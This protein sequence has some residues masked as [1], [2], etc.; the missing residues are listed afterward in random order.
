MNNS[1]STSNIG[2]VDSHND[3]VHKFTLGEHENLSVL[4]WNVNDISDQS[5]GNKAEIDEFC[6]IIEMAPI[7]CLQETKGEVNVPNYRC[8]NKNRES[9][10]SGGLCIGVQRSLLN[11][12]TP[13]KTESSDIQA[14]SI[15][16]A[17]TRGDKNIT[18]INIYDSQDYSSYKVRMKKLGSEENTLEALLHLIGEQIS[19]SDIMLVG[20]L[21]ARTGTINFTPSSRDWM[22]EKIM[23]APASCRASKDPVLNERG[24]KFIDLLSSCNLTLLNG[25]VVGDIFGEFTCFKYNGQSVADYM[26][27]TPNLKSLV[28]WFKVLS[29]TDL[30]DHKPLLCKF[31]VKVP[32]LPAELIE[33]LYQKAPTKPKWDG[34]ATT[35]EFI[36]NLNRD[37]Q[38]ARL[39]EL[40]ASP[41]ENTENIYS[42]NDKFINILENSLGTERNPNSSEHKVKLFS[43]KKRRS[44]FRPKQ[45]WF[46]AE[47]IT[48]KRELNKLTRR[49][50]KNP[51]DD[52]LRTRF[53]TAKKEYKKLIKKK[54]SLFFIELNQEILQDDQISWKNLKTVKK[55]S[56]KP[57]RLDIFDMSKFYQFFMDLYKKRDTKFPTNRTI[58]QVEEEVSNILNDKILENEIVHAVKSL[59]NGKAVGLDRV[60]NEQLKSAAQNSRALLV[61]AKLF[62][63]CLDLG[64]YPW[65]TTI[66]S[67]LHKKGCIY[68][69]DNYRAIAI[70]SN[71]GKLFATILLN[72]LLKFREAHCP[73]TTN[74]L[75]FCK[76]A[77]T[78]DHLFT[79]TTCVDKY[80]N[81]QKKRLYSCFVDFQKAFDSISR[82]ALLYKLSTLGIGGKFLKCLE[83]MYKNS[84]AKIKLI[85]KI[86]DSFDILAGT[87]QGH[88]MSPELF[89]TYIHEL[90]E[91]LNN[92]QG[93]ECPALNDI[94]LTHLLWADDLVLLALTKKSL[95]EMIRELESFCIEWGLTVNIKKTAIMIFNRSGRQLKEST[96]FQYEGREIPTA[97]TYC[98]LG[99]TFSL[100]GSFKVAQNLLRQKALRA[101]FGLK[102]EVDLYSISKVAVLKLLDS[103]ILP[104]VSYG[105][106]VW[107]T[108]T[109]GIK[110]FAN[111]T[112]IAKQS[113]LTSLAVDPI[114]RLHLSILKWTLGVGK[115]T[116]NAAVW[117]DCGRTPLVVR[118]VKQVTDFYNRLAKMDLDDSPALARHAFAEQKRLGLGW[119]NTLAKMLNTLDENKLEHQL[120]NSL[121]CQDRA[122]NR[123]IATWEAE[124]HNNSKLGFYNEVKD[125]FNMEPYLQIP[126]KKWE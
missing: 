57:S 59:K 114:E 103:L 93:L 7:F 111:T 77:R 80:V 71:L 78:V 121:L 89:K 48:T 10:R 31:S 28:K 52:H 100:S 70:G 106:E 76:N 63:G 107:I 46:D 49:Y 17:Y 75:G 5:L 87:E 118:F 73:D 99:I 91:R 26:A 20:D 94:I 88:P 36:A 113:V 60:L 124:R 18:L 83:F 50:G 85:S 116:S 3:S 96:E 9:S 29:L 65:N 47:C 104:V 6:N 15:S 25:S 53:Y 108:S 101:Y 74:Q 51:L 14:I 119:F 64:V 98:Y 11:H 4:S 117:G 1:T 58:S 37:D 102:S 105:I 35:Q 69:P 33:K 19:H 97:K 12:I 81:N 40:S 43:K 34:D 90:S 109:A 120:Y 82:E 125:S 123:F 21:N 13:V 54:K 56:E 62:N 27:V 126:P 45:K 23:N 79:L 110:A 30:S 38:A 55:F 112:I 67:P 24:N 122:R 2:A 44:K 8:F 22:D 86:S 72:R 66:V 41:L 42:L 84:K 32:L 115:T 61:L 92:M 95:Q 16:K 39:L 68:N